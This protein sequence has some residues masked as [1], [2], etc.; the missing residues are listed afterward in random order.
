M[1]K[2]IHIRQCYDCL[3]LKKIERIHSVT[4]YRL[5]SKDYT[6]IPQQ[7]RDVCEDCKKVYDAERR[8]YEKSYY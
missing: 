2:I 6:F 3:K 7:N 4:S 5:N 1:G 8:I